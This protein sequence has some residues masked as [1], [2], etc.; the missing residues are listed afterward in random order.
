MKSKKAGLARFVLRSTESLYS[1]FVGNALVITRICFQQQIRETEDLKI[2][3][4]V[5]I[6]KKELD[7]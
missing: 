3:G 2:Q 1:A 7:V 5:T 6:S 4:K